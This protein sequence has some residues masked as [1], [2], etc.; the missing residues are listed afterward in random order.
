[1]TAA[2]RL[3][4]EANAATSLL[5]CVTLRMTAGMQVLYNMGAR[6]MVV[7]H[8]PQPG[9]INS[10]ASANGYQVR[11]ARTHGCYCMA[12]PLRITALFFAAEHRT[13]ADATAHVCVPLVLRIPGVAHRHWHVTV[14]QE[15][16]A[17][18]PR[19]PRRRQHECAHA[20]GSGAWG[21]ALAGG[22]RHRALAEAG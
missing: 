21:G 22:G 7:G 15:R 8:T 14:G 12:L 11:R 19:N 18:M 16:A 9:G 20:D 3:P 13:S 2:I 4:L 6:R 10:F 17:R 1:M 5:P